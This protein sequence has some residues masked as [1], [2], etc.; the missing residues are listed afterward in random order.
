[1]P[2][3]E[4]LANAS[5]V[6]VRLGPTGWGNI[7]LQRSGRHRPLCPISAVKSRFSCIS[8]RCVNRVPGSKT[9][10]S[11]AHERAQKGKIVRRRR[12]SRITA[13][14]PACRVNYYVDMSIAWLS[15]R[16]VRHNPRIQR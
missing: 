9:D 10:Q 5:K 14:P 8:S 1:M 2:N 4:R 6:A 13:F 15:R 3:E 16:L 11:W 7:V 12:V